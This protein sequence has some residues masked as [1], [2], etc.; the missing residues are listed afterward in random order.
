[1]PDPNALWLELATAMANAVESLQDRLGVMENLDA[2][3][4]AARRV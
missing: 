2:M 3:R 4:A 1:M